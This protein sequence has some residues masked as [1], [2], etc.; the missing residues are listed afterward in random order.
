MSDADHETLGVPFRTPCPPEMA[1][2]IGRAIW[3]FL[4][5]E[6]QVASL[7]VDCNEAD[8]HEARHLM[9]G[10]KANRTNRAAKRYA[11]KG[12]TQVAQLLR[13]ASDAFRDA[14]TQYR[15]AL[16]HA[17][18][19]TVSRNAEGEGL[20]GLARTTANGTEGLATSPEEVLE[21]ATQIEAA[22]EPVADARRAVRGI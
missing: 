1:C 6:G 19:F 7:L 17:S 15:N 14:T 11:A 21:M 16:S 2:A 3:N 13:A 4:S 12:D 22:R 8:R 5:L 10:D 20:P 9:A 18:L